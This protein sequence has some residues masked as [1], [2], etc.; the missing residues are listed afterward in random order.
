MRTA[1]RLTALTITAA[2]LLAAC[3]SDD[4][5]TSTSSTT[6]EA[7]PTT[8]EASEPEGPQDIDGQTLERVAGDICAAIDTWSTA[9]AEGYEATPGA[10]AEA[11]DTDAARTVVIGWM[12]GM[13]NDTETLVAELSEVDLSDAEPLEPF[14]ADLGDR[15]STLNDIVETHEQQAS[16]ITTDDPQAFGLEV[17]ALVQE[18]NASLAELPTV[19]DELNQSYPSADLQAALASAC[20]LDPLGDVDPEAE[21]DGSEDD[22]A[23]GESTEPEASEEP[24]AADD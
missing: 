20:D 1:S 4:D 6:S 15:F 7:A 21:D 19:F 13:S 16:D 14:L 9:I 8:T 10:L 3:G 24:D 17:T 11:D 12:E 23:T 5:E 18:F 2:L 22:E